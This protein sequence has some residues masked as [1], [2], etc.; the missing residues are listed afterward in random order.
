MALYAR[1]PWRFLGQ[2][3][4]DLFVVLWGVGWWL[5]G[6][7]VHRSIDAVADP[8]RQTVTT[9]E[10][11]A[12]NFRDA[13]TQT[14]AVPGLGEQLRRP[15][16]A[17]ADSLSG[18]TAAANAQ[19][20]SVERLATIVG[21]LVF[22]IPVTVL[23]ALWLPQRIRFVLR[24]RAAQQFIDSDADLSLFALRAMTSQPMHVLARIS[25]DPVKAW[26]TGD[27]AVINQLAEVEL[28]RIGMRIPDTLKPDTLK[29]DTPEP[30]TLA[31]PS[32]PGQG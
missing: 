31:Q 19:I 30:D 8:A 25:D 6:S 23:V 32:T 27:T 2:L 18:L 1:R 3:S 13:G 21:W 15:F 12:G 5:V 29:P 22:L 9:T 24:A 14:S 4:A 11:L 10:Q 16:D 20:A 7:F 17:A 26:R 28:R